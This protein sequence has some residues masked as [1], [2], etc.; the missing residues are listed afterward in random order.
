M[1]MQ[2]QGTTA[3][4][5][6]IATVEELNLLRDKWKAKLETPSGIRVVVGMA[7]CGISAGANQVYEAFRNE[8]KKRGL[9]HVV[10]ERS[11]VSECAST[12]R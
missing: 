1:T 10:V 9:D 4:M 7:T 8:I 6:R 3:E 2:P 5:N 11:G 12:N